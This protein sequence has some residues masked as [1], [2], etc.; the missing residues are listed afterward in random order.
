MLLTMKG[1]PRFRASRPR[2]FSTSRKAGLP[3]KRTFVTSL[4]EVVYVDL[5]M[6]SLAGVAEEGE[7]VPLRALPEAE[8]LD[9]TDRRPPERQRLVKATDSLL[10]AF[11]R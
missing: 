4:G 9:L 6:A 3:C 8:A 1:L 7:A 11:R 5:A 10:C 2:G